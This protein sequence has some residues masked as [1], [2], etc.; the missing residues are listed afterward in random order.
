MSLHI[1]RYV[2]RNWQ[3]HLTLSTQPDYFISS[4]LGTLTDHASKARLFTLEEAESYV[5]MDLPQGRP[6]QTMILSEDET[7]LLIIM[8]S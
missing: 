7:S 2:P 5:C 8:D 3:R 4:H 6:V 1:I